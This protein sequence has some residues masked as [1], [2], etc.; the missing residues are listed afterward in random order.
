MEEKEREIRLGLEAQKKLRE[1]LE[2][3]RRDHA[4]QTS[5]H[6][7]RI[8]SLLS[9]LDGLQNRIE[10]RLGDKEN[11]KGAL[12]FEEIVQASE[13]CL[14]RECE[15]TELAE[16]LDKHFGNVQE[17][18]ESA[19]LAVENAQISGQET[20]SEAEGKRAKVIQRLEAMVRTLQGR[21]T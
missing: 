1:E 20:L 13:A 18:S 9:T 16:S 14:L 7:A 6:L 5:A 4:Q 3:A 12:S 10:A 8:S 11:F 19:R 2:Q 15:L 17:W 21:G